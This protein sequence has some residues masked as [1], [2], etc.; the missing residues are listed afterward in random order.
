MGLEFSAVLVAE[1]DGIIILQNKAAQRLL[2]IGTGNPCWSVVGGLNN[3]QGLPCRRGCVLELL[4]RGIDRSLNCQC[5]ING[6]RYHLNCIPVNGTA[7]CALSR[8][9]GM[10]PAVFQLLTSREREILNLLATGETT[11][12]IGDCLGI[13][14]F[15]VQ[16]HV[17]KM[18]DKF[19]A[20]TQ[21][22]VVARGFQLGYL[23]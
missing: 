6:Q 8:S 7:V 23:G 2:G 4:S 9:T 13:S 12:S 16:T 17:E 5:K 15:T 21:A 18:R 3:A 1:R 10:A 20:S 22:A 11:R 19:A 14:R